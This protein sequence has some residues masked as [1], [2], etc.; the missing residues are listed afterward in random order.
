MRKCHWATIIWLAGC[1]GLGT[2]PDRSPE[3][4]GTV[5]L[6]ENTA[7]GVTL[8]GLDLD[9]DL[10]ADAVMRV[11]Q[12]TRIVDVSK[13]GDA[14]AGVDRLTPGTI[15]RAWTDGIELRSDPPQYF[16]VRLEVE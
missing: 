4:T 8:V 16:A 1:S 3:F 11:M 15:V 10:I 6:V 9:D 14:I 5:A 2:E 7:A 12:S 13:N